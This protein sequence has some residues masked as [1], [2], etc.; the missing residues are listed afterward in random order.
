[1]GLCPFVPSKLLRCMGL[2]LFVPRVHVAM[3]GAQNE[4]VSLVLT[5]VPICASSDAG[6]IILLDASS[7]QGTNPGC[8]NLATKAAL[9]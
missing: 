1:M 5:F 2:C 9:K 4:I 7:H 6:V 8:E 3:D